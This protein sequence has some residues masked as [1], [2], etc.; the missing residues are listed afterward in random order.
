MEEKLQNSLIQS[1]QMDL[2]LKIEKEEFEEYRSIESEKLEVF[3][4]DLEIQA[5]KLKNKSQGFL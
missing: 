4:K 3:K 1:S 5:E 2:L